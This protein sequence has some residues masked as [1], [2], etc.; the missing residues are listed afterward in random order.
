[1]LF[2]LLIVALCLLT[3]SQR[4]Y[5]DHISSIF[6]SQHVSIVYIWMVCCKKLGHNGFISYMNHV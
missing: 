1:M 3:F 4:Y 2:S 6:I 5:C